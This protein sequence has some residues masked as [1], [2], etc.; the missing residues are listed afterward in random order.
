[1]AKA[2]FTIKRQEMKVV[3][4][5]GLDAPREL[6]F[7]AFTVPHFI[8]QWSGP[9]MLTTTVDKMYVRP[10]GVWRYVQ[11]DHEGNECAFNGVY[12][13]IVP[14]ERLSYTFEFEAVPGHVSIQTATFEGLDGKTKV[15]ST[16]VYYTVEDLDWMVN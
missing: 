4:G 6:V 3:M 11:R 14:P 2:T 10:V 12:R 13:E 8:R 1:M 16:A 15:T 9:R 5:R 7:K